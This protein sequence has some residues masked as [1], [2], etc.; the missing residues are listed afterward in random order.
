[1]DLLHE[2]P[3]GSSLTGEKVGEVLSGWAPF[4]E[5]LG[6]VTKTRWFGPCLP[7]Y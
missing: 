3:T 6:L 5:R 1:M 7:P 2:L 4:R